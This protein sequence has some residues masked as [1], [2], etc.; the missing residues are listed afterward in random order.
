MNQLVVSTSENRYFQIKVEDDDFKEL[1]VETDGGKRSAFKRTVT[2]LWQIDVVSLVS[3][4]TTDGTVRFYMYM[5]EQHNQININDN[6]L[7]VAPGAS[8]EINSGDDSF[9]MY[10]AIDGDLR[11]A[12]NLIPSAKAYVQDASVEF[13]NHDTVVEMGVRL[14]T[15]ISPISTA[16]LVVSNR[17][18]K[19]HTNIDMRIEKV[20]H[21]LD[22]YINHLSVRFSADTYLKLISSFEYFD[23]NTAVFDYHVAVDLDAQRVSDY[24]FRVGAGTSFVQEFGV[25]VNVEQTANLEWYLTGAG[26]LSSR[27]GTIGNHEYSLLNEMSIKPRSGTKPLILVGEYPSKAQDNGLAFFKYLMKQPDVE[28]YY[29][30]AP[31]SPDLDDLAQYM[32]HVLYYKS[33]N[34]VKKFMEADILI[35]DHTPNYLVPIR[36]HKTL[37]KVSKTP[38]IFLQHGITGI[39]NMEYL[40]GRHSNPDLM[41]KFV[42]SSEREFRVVRDELGYPEQDILLTGFPRFD[43]LLK[44]CNFITTFL[45]RKRLLIMPSWR[46]GMDWL[47]DDEFVK[48]N[49]YL[50][51]Q[52]LITNEHFKEICINNGIVVDFYLH[53]N[54]QKF[55]HLFH[56]DFVNILREGEESVQALLKR[57]GVLV[58]DYSSVGMDFAI[59][60]RTVLYF[61]FEKSMQE[62]RNSDQV[63]ELLPGPIIRST[64]EL[65]NQIKDATKH[66]RLQPQYEKLLVKNIYAFKDR[67]ASQR[68]YQSMMKM[69]HDSL[70]K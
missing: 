23:Y 57:H 10:V 3:L 30:V 32:D 56:S 66:N 1:F 68:I 42:V 17:S 64:E 65:L 67:H 50:E 19:R 6:D 59:Q 49:Y 46:R 4:A 29:I 47:T 61:Q 36:T 15:R 40:Y 55:S 28:A 31:N 18:E 53:T 35:H 54:F 26:N 39:K 13:I 9:V 16:Y 8:L 38:R 11:I 20:E 14:E 63:K 43:T 34:H 41:D 70:S 25:P 24:R 2:G 21:E 45:T 48:T 51:Y 12:R 52:R 22:T 62:E 69:W 7:I 58:T 37:A 44:N 33:V 5:D 60:R 27:I